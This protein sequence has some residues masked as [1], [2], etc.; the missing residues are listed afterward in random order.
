MCELT[1]LRWRISDSHRMNSSLGNR[2]SSADQFRLDLF[3]SPHSSFCRLSVLRQMTDYL[4]EL[5]MLQKCLLFIFLHTS[6][7]VVTGRLF[8]QNNSAVTECCIYYDDIILIDTDIFW[9]FVSQK[10]I[11]LRAVISIVQLTT[12]CIAVPMSPK[13]FAIFK[14]LFL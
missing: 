7:F 9:V 8:F 13:F 1:S 4:A 2:G 11:D 3:L 12:T 5:D 10:H 14:L 6:F